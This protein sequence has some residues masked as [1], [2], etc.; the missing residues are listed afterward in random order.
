[1][2]KISSLIKLLLDA[3]F[4]RITTKASPMMEPVLFMHLARRSYLILGMVS[5]LSFLSCN[6][7][8]Q[9]GGPQAG[10]VDVYAAGYIIN[11]S[12]TSK[13]IAIYWRNENYF[14][15]SDGTKD[16]QAMSIAVS[17]ND[18]Y[19][20][21][22]ETDFANFIFSAH[23]ICWKNGNALY[24]DEGG[25]SYSFATSVAV[26]GNDVYVAGYKH[27]VANSAPVYWKNG[28]PN[29]LDGGLIYG[30]AN[31]ITVSGN[32]VYIA[33]NELNNFGNPHVA[34]YWKNGIAFPLT[35]GTTLADAVAITVSG[36]D[37]YVLGYQ[38]DKNGY[39][40]PKYW[41]NGSP[42]PLGDGSV[43]VVYSIAVSGNNVFVA[44]ASINA[45]YPF[46]ILTAKYWKNGIPTEL[47]KTNNSLAE[48]IATC[49][50]DIYVV[51]TSG[52]DNVNINRRGLATLWRN[53][54]A[55]ELPGQTNA[56]LG[57]ANSIF[58][59]RRNSRQEPH[60]Y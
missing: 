20:A 27:N 8:S 25:S 32:D 33:G 13:D 15:L 38:D 19:V 36:N 49:G 46:T 59:A 6:K 2:K 23:A 57:I 12:S 47:T 21:G 40:A 9:H 1:M 51:G 10:A 41:K 42:V 50:N 34:K 31:A 14:L 22:T 52:E 4:G 53:G 44:G 55:F 18:V 54:D 56:F 39:R 17:G 30:Y 16:A 37:V 43:T 24:L 7:D 58:I 29:Y 28:I 35:D 48:S 11:T 45:E 60:K 26:S 5:L 3:L